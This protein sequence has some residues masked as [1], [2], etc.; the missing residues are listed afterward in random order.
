MVPEGLAW[1]MGEGG[2]K[3][4]T[5]GREEEQWGTTEMERSA[6]DRLSRGAFGMLLGSRHLE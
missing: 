2:A 3:L 5:G 1:E 4:H 6:L